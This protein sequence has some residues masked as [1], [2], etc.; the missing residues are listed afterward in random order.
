[1][2]R[3]QERGGFSG[4]LLQFVQVARHGMPFAFDR[5][6]HWMAIHVAAQPK[7]HVPAAR[8]GGF[9]RK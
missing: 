4:I 5:E 3:S 1:M 6:M 7:I 8:S 9:I 2:D